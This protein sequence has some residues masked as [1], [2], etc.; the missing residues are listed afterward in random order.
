MS[1]YQPIF[2]NFGGYKKKEKGPIDPRVF[3]KK[4]NLDA[5]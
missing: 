2:Q 4:S 3:M 1:L 5:H